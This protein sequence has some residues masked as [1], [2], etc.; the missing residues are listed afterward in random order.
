MG[1]VWVCVGDACKRDRN[2]W[3]CFYIVRV[4]H[5]GRHQLL[6]LKLEYAFDLVRNAF[7]VQHNGK[8]TT[9]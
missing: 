3:T 7:I 2:E 9:T 8:N 1:S 5:F 4:R 6:L